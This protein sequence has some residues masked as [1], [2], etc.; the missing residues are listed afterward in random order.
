M[1][2][3]AIEIEPPYNTELFFWNIT[4]SA[5][6]LSGLI[7]DGC[8]LLDEARCRF[9]SGRR[10]REWLATRA[11]L[12]STPYSSCRIIYNSKGAP[13]LDRKGKHISISHTGELVAIAVSNAPVGLDIESGERNATKVTRL[14]LRE[15]E[16]EQAGDDNNEALRLW[17]VK[18]AAFKLASE[19]VSV[20]KEI[21]TTFTSE[22][23]GKYTYNIKYPD[24]KNA[25]CRTYMTGGLFISVSSLT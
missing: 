24:G 6:E 18:E 5:E 3:I 8:E 4:E 19:N 1:P 22:E 11:L 15:R 10:R 25:I 2:R 9:K 13:S 14:F 16:I 20:L 12:Q 23:N 7:P 17:T 21:E